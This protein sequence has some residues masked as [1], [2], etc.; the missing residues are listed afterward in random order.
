MVQQGFLTCAPQKE[1]LLYRFIRLGYRHGAGVTCRLAD[2]TVNALNRALKFLSNE[3]HYF[4]EF[5][6]FSGPCGRAHGGD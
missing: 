4:K 6:R 3:A 2:D 5:L 1:L